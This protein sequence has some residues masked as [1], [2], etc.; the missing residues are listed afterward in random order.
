MSS[1]YRPNHNFGLSGELNDAVHTYPENSLVHPGEEARAFLSLA[2]PDRQLG[3]LYPGFTFTV[4]E[5]GR[6]VGNGSIVSVLN[7]KLRRT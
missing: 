2:A 6:V 4:Q 1:G 7:A 3:R 5:G